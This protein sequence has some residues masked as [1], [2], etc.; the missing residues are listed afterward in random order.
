MECCVYGSKISSREDNWIQ[1][2][3]FD[4]IK[5]VAENE[6]DI[7]CLVKDGTLFKTM[8]NNAQWISVKK[9]VTQIYSSEIHNIWLTNQGEIFTFG[10]NKSGQLGLG[11]CMDR[12]EPH[13]VSLNNI[14]SLCGGTSKYHSACV[15][16]NGEVFS[17]GDAKYGKLG[18]LSDSDQLTPKMISTWDSEFVPPVITSVVVGT[19]CTMFL[20]TNDLVYTCGHG[21]LGHDDSLDRCVPK[22]VQALLNTSIK[23]IAISDTA[24]FVLTSIFFESSYFNIF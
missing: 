16:V 13:K 2:N 8:K 18:Y 11:D 9:Q 7:Y 4:E 21:S 17:W 12:N 14:K 24:C 6:N 10:N 20:S 23:Q 15:S 5:Q 3:S 19:E 22:L 1:F